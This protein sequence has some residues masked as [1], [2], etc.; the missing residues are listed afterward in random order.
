MTITI[1][2]NLADMLVNTLEIFD[3]CNDA[4]AALRLI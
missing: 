2:S 3:K 4:E 1:V